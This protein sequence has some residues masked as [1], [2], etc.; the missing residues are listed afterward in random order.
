MLCAEGRRVKATLQ[1]QVASPARPVPITA[2]RHGQYRLWMP[3]AIYGVGWTE[4][5]LIPML[6]RPE[7]RKVRGRIRDSAAPRSAGGRLGPSQRERVAG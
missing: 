6:S 2:K 1:R 4:P 7:M 3:R 5:P